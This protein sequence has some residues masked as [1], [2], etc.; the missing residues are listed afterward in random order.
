MFLRMIIFCSSTAFYS[1]SNN[2]ILLIQMITNE[3]LNS[4]STFSQH[5][6]R[7]SKSNYMFFNIV[8]ARNVDVRVT[9]NR[10]RKR[11]SSDN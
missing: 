11:F 2:I 10:F 6:A 7:N 1:H 3:R 9:K 8:Y 5:R 4:H